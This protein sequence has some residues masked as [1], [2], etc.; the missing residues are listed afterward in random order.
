M[1]IY[2]P[3][4]SG[5]FVGC[6]GLDFGFQQG[7]YDLAWANEFDKDAS[8]SYSVLTGH[9]VVVDDIWNVIEKVPAT[10]ILIGGPPCQAFSLVGKRLENDPR[11]QLVFAYEKVV[12]RIKPTAFVMENVPGLMASRI[13]GQ[14]LHLYLAEQFNKMG[15][16]VSVLKLTATDFFVPQKRQRVFMIGHKKKGKSFEIIGSDEFAK[17]L[18]EDGLKVP[19]SVAEAL[20]DL[21]SPLPKGSKNLTEYLFAPH[22]AYSR[23]MR[24]AGGGEVS[25]QSM[26][27]MSELDR[28]FVK[29]IP[30]G[31]NYTH[32][33]DSIS[34]QR[35]MS[36]KAS[37]GRTTTYGRL[38]PEK[39]AYTINT[40]FNRP[41]VGANYH[42]REERLITVREA[43][44]LQSFPDHFIPSFKSQR[45]LHMQVGN[46]VP[47]L[48]AQAIAESLKKLL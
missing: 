12:E 31:G 7:G 40:Y 6:G 36:F 39:P 43:M 16:E 28:Q 48:M 35:I 9:E 18:G 15:Y 46:A 1:S 29:H 19:V 44:R 42:H 3:S 32:I 37:G 2:K 10:D 41:N 4:V 47:P 25:L 30:P 5:L 14:R 23:I 27:T 24:K 45:S 38:H 13:D 8:V 17:I 34:T 11:G 33:P 22:S 20:D 21:P 26:P